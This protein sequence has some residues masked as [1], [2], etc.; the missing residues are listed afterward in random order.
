VGNPDKLDKPAA[1]V[2][3]RREVEAGFRLIELLVVIMIIGTMVNFSG[4]RLHQG[5]WGSKG[6][7]K[8]GKIL[9]K[10]LF[11]PADTNPATMS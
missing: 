2:P 11:S 1:A 3:V 8:F 9:L 6:G 10:Y 5:G 7:Q 4:Q